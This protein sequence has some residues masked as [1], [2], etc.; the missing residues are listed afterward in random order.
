MSGLID[1]STDL[2]TT[3]AAHAPAFRGSSYDTPNVR[4]AT[5]PTRQASSGAAGALAGSPRPRELSICVGAA[6]TR[7]RHDQL[8][9][10]ARHPGR[11]DGACRRQSARCHSGDAR[12]H[13]AGRPA[14]PRQR[15]RSTCAGCCVRMTTAT[16]CSANTLKN[17]GIAWRD[18][19][20]F[21]KYLRWWK[22]Q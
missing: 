8:A 14:S 4:L 6:R 18:Y 22:K 12:A 10:R 7:H 2:P 20:P 19:F 13:P 11:G 9:P 5:R 17:W 21:G 15:T 3:G 1:S 16:C